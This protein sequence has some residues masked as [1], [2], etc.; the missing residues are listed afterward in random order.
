[1]IAK[2][3]QELINS[4]L[5]Q[6]ATLQAQLA[7]VKDYDILPLGI[8]KNKNYKDL[9]RLAE[10]AFSEEKYL[11]AFLIQ[12]CVIEGVL[13]EYAIKK[14]SSII[15]QSSV[16]QKKFKNF[17]SVK[18]AK[19]TDD[20]FISGKIKK[21]LYEN[22]NSYRQK[23]NHVIHHLLE[24]D[25]KEKL[26]K[27]LKRVYNLGKHMKGFIVDD[28]SNEIQGKLTVTQLE[29]QVDMLL[30][31]IRQLQ[32]QLDAVVNSSTETRL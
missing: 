7:N 25:D 13:K 6:I 16:L 24:D 23:R 5:A 31:Q 19:L 21:D 32:S 14:L 9:V 18:L 29:A 20:L 2:E 28:M 3:L 4:L 15:S 11:E 1:M 26:T 22:L 12:S 10:R 17:E 27:E 30:F 8:I